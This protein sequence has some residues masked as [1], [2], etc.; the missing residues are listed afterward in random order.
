M[1]EEL[2]GQFD[3]IAMDAIESAEGV[4]CSLEEFLKGVKIILEAVRDR[5][6][7]VEMELR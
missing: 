6:R 3:K 5:M 1:K 2:E 7:G 4:D